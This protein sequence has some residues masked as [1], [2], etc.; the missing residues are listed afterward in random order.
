MKT[1]VIIFVKGVIVCAM[2]ITSAMCLGCPRSRTVKLEDGL[3]QVKEGKC[4][5]VVVADGTISFQRDA[6]HKFQYCGDT[7][8]I[9]RAMPMLAEALSAASNAGH[10]V[11][12]MDM[13]SQ[14]CNHAPAGTARQFAEPQR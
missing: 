8:R 11:S 9:A 14:E 7:N 1:S 10:A 12:F 4:S 2:L 6:F 13:R 3:R 5:L